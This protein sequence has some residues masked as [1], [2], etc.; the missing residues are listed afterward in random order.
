MMVMMLK[1]MIEKH[2]ESYVEVIIGQ[3][4]HTRT[5]PGSCPKEF[6][7]DNKLCDHIIHIAQKVEIF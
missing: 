4:I 3:Y 6:D 5:S 7:S 1:M 2:Y